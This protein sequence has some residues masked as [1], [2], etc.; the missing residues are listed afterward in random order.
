MAYYSASD[1]IFRVF[2][3]TKYFFGFG[4][5][6]QMTDPGWKSP[7]CASSKPEFF[8]RHRPRCISIHYFKEPFLS[9]VITSTWRHKAGQRGQNFFTYRLLILICT[10]K[11]GFVRQVYLLEL[12]RT[13][14]CAQLSTN[15]LR[16]PSLLISLRSG[17]QPRSQGSLLH[18]PRE[19]REGE[20]TWERGC[21][22]TCLHCEEKWQKL[23]WN[24]TS[25]LQD[26]VGGGSL[27]CRN[28]A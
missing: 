20:R 9:H 18:V 13:L 16:L 28:R 7:L 3:M 10:E 5:A 6:P 1:R 23:I 4:L 21:P 11:E 27:R 19:R 2:R 15:I 14:F 24:V 17:Y 8:S 22:Y 25:P 12:F 26:R